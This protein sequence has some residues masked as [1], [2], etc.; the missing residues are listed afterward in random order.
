MVVDPHKVSVF[1]CG[2]QSTR[3]FAK[4]FYYG[5]YANGLVVG[6]WNKLYKRDY[7]KN[8]QFEGRLSEG[9]EWIAWVLAKLGKI[10][11]EREFC[12]IM[13]ERRICVLCEHW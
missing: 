11:Y 1:F 12:P 10:F 5:S 6:V 2:K 8:I 13:T 9:E 7:I 3:N 4:G